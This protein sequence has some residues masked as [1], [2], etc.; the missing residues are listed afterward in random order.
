MTEP[1]PSDVLAL[2]PEQAAQLLQISRS[3]IYELIREDRVP[4]IRV[5]GSI[6]IPR[7]ALEA[8]LDAQLA[9]GRGS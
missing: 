9:G 2:K 7:R 6:R 3:R 1:V 5:G 8:W 4:Y